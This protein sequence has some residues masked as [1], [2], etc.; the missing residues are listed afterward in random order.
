MSAI[1]TNGIDVNYPVPGVNNDSQ[2]FRTNFTSIKN[3]LNTAANEITDLQNK[4][5]LK[6]ALANSSINNDM[7]NT[8]I[9][10]ASI[11]GFR[12]TTYNLG[13]NLNGTVLV[14]CSLGDVQYGTVAANT[15]LQFGSWAPTGT[16]STLYLL[17]DVSNANATI[18]F[19]SEVLI[20]NDNGTSTLENYANISNVVTITAPYGV[21]ELDYKLTTLDCG[22]TITLEPTNRPRQATQI[23]QRTPIPTG[24]NGDV[25]GTT[26]I[27]PSI[28][29]L[30]ITQ[31]FANDYIITANTS[32]LY[33]DMPLVFTGN[34]GTSGLT[35]GTTYYTKIIGNSTAFTVSSTIGGANV[36]L[37]AY[38]TANFYCNPVRYLYVATDSYNATTVSPTVSSTNSSGNIT[39]ST[40]SG[41]V[42]DSPIFFAGDVVGGLAENTIYYI[43]SL[44]GGANIT[45]SR[46]RTNGVADT[47]VTLTTATPSN[48]CTAT[49]YVGSDI[50]KRLQLNP[51]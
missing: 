1:N 19:P 17:L 49:A 48:T 38:S 13:N 24:F 41:L 45:I 25:A 26:C 14:N 44:P 39:L 29:Q 21:T 47:A 28:D 7:A 43:K 22:N 2:G 11:L 4:V 3:N 50:W 35:A 8:L 32:S 23:Q 30:T 36:N 42:I 33:V 18:S 27:D 16:L 12:N 6:Q 15:T 40:V 31:T 5:V 10:N 46:S 20:S 9:S 34:T 37:S 51:W